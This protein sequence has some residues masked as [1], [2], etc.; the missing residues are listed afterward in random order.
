MATHSN[1]L[2]WEIPWTEEPDRLQFIGSQRV[3]HS[4]EHTHWPRH[5]EAGPIRWSCS[6]Q[7]ECWWFHTSL[8]LGKTHKH[9]SAHKHTS[10]PLLALLQK[11]S[12]LPASLGFWPKLPATVSSSIS[13]TS[14]KDNFVKARAKCTGL[15]GLQSSPCIRKPGL[16]RRVRFL[17]RSRATLLGSP[18]FP[19]VVKELCFL[20]HALPTAFLQWKILQ[21]PRSLPHLSETSR[22]LMYLTPALWWSLN[23]TILVTPLR[24]L[25]PV[26][27]EGCLDLSAVVFFF[28]SVAPWVFE[29]ET[30]RFI[31]NSLYTHVF[32]PHPLG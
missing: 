30:G 17:C 24:S 19:S 9:T 20:N 5:A 13:F 11:F 29:M 22:I 32:S 3:R 12:F 10:T 4:W 27:P 25:C 21:H 26:D 23:S 2:D 8:F 18:I 28:M 1:I 15:E 16:S 6:R 31:G 7:A 14:W